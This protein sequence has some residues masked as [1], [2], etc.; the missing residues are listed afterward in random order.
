MSEQ[1]Y[2]R[3]APIPEPGREGIAPPPRLLWLALGL[4]LF[5]VIFGLL[6]LITYQREQLV[7][8]LIPLAL[9]ALIILA[10]G[11]VVT[12]YIFRRNLPRRFWLWWL[13][14]LLVVGVFGGAGLG[15]FV[16][17]S[18]LPPRYQ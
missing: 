18:V 16:Y 3:Q 5:I 9:V 17:R 14:A 15:V 4:F 1:Q 12:A 7:I 10:A 13:I 2:T 8:A 6:A 11:S